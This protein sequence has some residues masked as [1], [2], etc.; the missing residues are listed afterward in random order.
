M[1]RTFWLAL[2]MVLSACTH[3]EVA[4]IVAPSRHATQAA[5]ASV[6]DRL[7]ARYNS[8]VTGCAGG[9]PAYECSGVLIR[10]ATYASSYDFWTHSPGAIQLGSST[11]SFIRNGVNSSS[12]DVTSG[13]ILMDPESARAAGKTELKA[14]CIF[15]FMANTQA[16]NRAMHGCGFANGANPDP[17]PADLS[18]CSKL[19]IP[20]ITPAAWIQNFNEHGANVVNQCSLSTTVATEFATSL[21]VR[22]SY[23]DI[24]KV[25]GNEML[26]ELWDTQAPANL[27]IEAIFY[28]AS[29]EGSLVNAQALKHAYQVKTN[30]GLP[31]VRL[32]FAVGAQRFVLKP[33]DQEDG[34]AVAQRLNARHADTSREC[35]DGKAAVYC[36]GVL[37]RAISYSTNY[38]AWNPNLTTQPIGG[39]SFSYLRGDVETLAMFN[40]K[41]QG[42]IL[43]ELNYAT[44][45]GLQ[46]INALC[47]YMVDANTWQR[48]DKGCG[49]HATT[50][51]S[52]TCAIEGV[53]TLAQLGAHFQAGNPANHQCSLAITPAPF[54]MAIDGRRQFVNPTTSVWQRYNEIMLAAWPMDIP[55]Q[56]PLD[57]IFYVAGTGEAEGLR[58]AKEI[59]KDLWRSAGGMIKP[60]VRMDL[61]AAANAVFSY[62]RE[63]QA[64]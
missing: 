60:V 33:V 50:P 63:D 31:I 41:A 10:R 17:L 19:A 4:D 6:A 7:V 20:A 47:V 40:D 38:H 2:L 9:T 18:N 58:Q 25:Y 61:K 54:M 55:A 30:I 29:K 27:P 48:A 32:D 13:F 51:G 36:N 45:A 59:Q 14:R 39:V 44:T 23:P 49:P 3:H 57:A 56:L 52:N 24:T 22:A 64:Y 26:F 15:P 42:I 11:F 21:A 12:A 62:R 46:P 34:W 35:A 53:V 1:K 37:V 28:N 16:G 5:S 8:S 43:R